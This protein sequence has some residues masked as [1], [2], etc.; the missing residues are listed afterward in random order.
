MPVKIRPEFLVL[1]KILVCDVITVTRFSI[2][3]CPVQDKKYG[4]FRRKDPT[5][6]IKKVSF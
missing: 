5:Y 1:F 6:L 3:I 2:N 4:Q